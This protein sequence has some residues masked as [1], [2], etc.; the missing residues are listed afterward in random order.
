[1]SYKWRALLAV[2]FGTYMATMDFNIVNVAL[3]TL[4][5]EFD[6]SPD[7]VIWATLASN[8][9][10]TGLTLTAGRTG[11][12][13]GRK[14]VYITGWVIFTIGMALAGFA[15]SIEQLVAVRFF[16]AIGVALAIANGN[17]IVTDAFPDNERGRA[18]G[19]TGAVV[20]AGLMSGPIFGGFILSAFSWHALFYLRVPIGLA[21]MTMAFFLLRE[22]EGMQGQRKLDIPGAVALFFALSGTLLAVNRGQS[23]G[24]SS[25]LILGLFAVGVA[26]LAAFLRIES[27][28]KSPV[29]SLALFKVRA[30]AASILSLVLTFSGQSAVTFLMPFYL[31]EVRGYSTAQTGLVVSTIPIMMLALSTPSGYVSDRWGF[32]HQTTLG[33]GIVTLGLLL[34]ATIHADT[35]I[36]LVVAR[37]AVIGLGTS[38]FMAPNT[39]MIMGSVSRNMLGTASASVATARNVGNATGL[40]MSG[41]ILVGVAIASSGLSGVRT[42]DLPADALLDGIRAA[43]LVAGLASSLAII[44]ST[45]RGKRRP[46]SAVPAVPV[47][48]LA[49]GS[50]ADF[51]GG[52]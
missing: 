44:A 18:L 37:L 36:M 49:E 52:S 33:A 30:F 17:A 7:T 48:A 28:A 13:W 15:N 51:P 32:R 11:D 34:L 22:S 20:G 35:P 24:W 39:S 16:Q 50:P 4:S 10:V 6:R 19:L 21:A 40:A 42:N 47:A 43:F 3:P 1:M 45:F 31:I 41:A 14:R 29:I 9:V 12:L 8:L 5:R 23:W 25:P 2:G 38:I 26:S 46:V 27:R